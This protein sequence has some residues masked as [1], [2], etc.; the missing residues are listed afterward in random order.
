MIVLVFACR[1]TLFALGVAALSACAQGDDPTLVA[2]KDLAGQVGP[3]SAPPVRKDPSEATG[4]QDLVRPGSAAPAAHCAADVPEFHPE[5][6]S[7]EMVLSLVPRAPPQILPRYVVQKSKMRQFRLRDIYTKRGLEDRSLREHPGLH[8][9]NFRSLNAQA[10]YGMFLDEERLDRIEDFRATALAVKAGG[11][12]A[13]A[14]AILHASE[15]AFLRDEYS[16][17]P[18]NSISDAPQPK[19]GTLLMNLMQ[20]RLIWIERHF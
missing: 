7:L 10:G 15:A 17:D 5:D 16:P 1:L 12:P 19:S 11:D 8:V 9:G 6:N 18:A 14:D 3:R 13:E 4:G 2:Q 20:M